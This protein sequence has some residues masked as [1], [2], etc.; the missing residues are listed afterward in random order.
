MKVPVVVL[1]GSTKFKEQW[2]ETAEKLYAE[3][4]IVLM[5]HF[6]HHA[7]DKPITAEEEEKC[8][9]MYRKMIN[10]AD[11]AYVINVGGY[12]GEHTKKDIAYALDNGLEVKYLEP[13]N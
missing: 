6:F 11:Y 2:Y 12:I 3:G 8:W 5:T 4:N 9:I 1:M 7:D 10:M 13:V